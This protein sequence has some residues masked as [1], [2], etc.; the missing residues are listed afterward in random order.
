[1]IMCL[2]RLRQALEEVRQ[3]IDR[4]CERAGRSGDVTLVAVT[5]GHPVEVM[6]GAR[7]AGLRII[8]ESRV[9]EAAAKREAVGDLGLAWHMVGHLQRNKVRDALGLF[10][11]IQSVDSRRLA[12][13]IQR[14]AE[15]QDRTVEVLIQ[16][17]ASRE[18][19]KY[20]FPVKEAVEVVDEIVQFDR[21]RVVGIM[22]MAALT[23]DSRILRDTFRR[24]RAVFER[25][26]DEVG[27]FEPRYLSM[28]MTNDYEI[29]VEEGSTM[30]RL[31]TALFGE[32][33]E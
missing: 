16:I 9:H 21:I 27:R 7:D 30:V 17:N 11:M 2:E 4:A 1:M 32:R 24:A 28:G 20:G 22:T 3:R 33:E 5:K 31:G 8:G 18:E 25:C 26:R 29:A 23:D 15:R 12:R 6:K 13:K 19:Q 14:E 10:D